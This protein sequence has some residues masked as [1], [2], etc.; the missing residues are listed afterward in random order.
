MKLLWGGVALFCANRN[1]AK[2][3]PTLGNISNAFHGQSATCNHGRSIQGLVLR[4]AALNEDNVHGV[5]TKGNDEEDSVYDVVI[6]GAGWAG[7]AA[8]RCYDSNLG[9]HNRPQPSYQ[10]VSNSFCFFCVLLI[11][12]PA[13]MLAKRGVDS[14]CILEA[15]DHVGGRASTV[16]HQWEDKDVPIDMGAMWIHGAAKNILNRLALKYNVDTRTS[17]YNTRI[18]KENSQGCYE[19]KQVEEFRDQLYGNGFFPFQEERQESTE[20]DEPLQ[21]SADLFVDQL[22]SP[23]EKQLARLFLRSLIEI[24][25]SGLLK[26]LSLWMWNDDYDLGGTI[27]S[28]D[29][30]L[31]QGHVSLI[32]PFAAQLVSN[33]KIVLEAPVETI[34]YRSKDLIKVA[35]RSK[36]EKQV[37]RTKKMIVTVPL[38]VLKA[39]SIAF[40]PKLPRWTKRSIRR[41]GMGRMNK[42]FLFWRKEDVFWPHD[43]EILGDLTERDS[44]FLFANPRPY[45]GDVPMLF[46]FF[47]G[48]VAD[49]VEEQYAKADPTTYENRIRDLAM[50]SL[51]SMFGDTIP[52]PE[53]VVVTMWNADEYTMGAYSFNQVGMG[54]H[55]R[56]LLAQ[57]IGRNQVFIAGEAAH[58][59]YFATTTGAFLTGRAAA[60][61]AIAA[62]QA[63]QRKVAV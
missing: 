35:Y 30:F 38:G 61:K 21:T 59:R 54:E 42:I 6:V 39:E 43:T 3:N 52:M 44:N 26:D 22:K 36:N 13:N 18:Y 62:L 4:R 50:K 2:R 49:R 12:V 47:Q 41:L 20:C 45:N 15:K 10:L 9:Y 58:R 25:Y 28:D 53:K 63:D 51:R 5:Q 1:L 27:E 55:D 23:V 46:A 11:T 60:R 48:P 17:T 40:V 16:N 24:E 31:P 19:E 37:L 34:D 8:G 56:Q 33:H 57:P 29:Y 32:E 7:L 14:F